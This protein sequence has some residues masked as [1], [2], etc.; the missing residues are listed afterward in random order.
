MVQ[1]PNSVLYVKNGAK[2]WKWWETAKQKQQIHAG[3]KNIPA[4]DIR[5]FDPTNIARIFK[6]VYRK[7]TRASLNALKRLLDRPSQ[8][9][10]ITAEEGCLWWCLVKDRAKASDHEKDGHGHFWLECARPW[11][12]ESIAGNRLALSDLPGSVAKVAG[13]KGTVCKPEAWEQVRRIILDQPDKPASDVN[14]HRM[15]YEQAMKNLIRSLGHKDFEQLVELIL[16]RSGW[17]RISRETGGV[18]EGI[19]LD[20]QN[21][22]MDERA[23]VQVKSTADQKTPDQYIRRFQ[24]QKETYSRLIFAVHSPKGRLRARQKNVHIWSG[25]EISYLVVRLGLGD[26]VLR[27][28][29]HL[30]P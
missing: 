26:L 23:F 17:E 1:L 28:R 13:F 22:A 9:I 16:A 14:R 7:D 29:G 27:M 12:N 25:D 3:W 8:H 4:A 24:R 20:V 5:N 6:R 18:Q 15:G 30:A 10:W 19:D 2:K 21:P 11:S